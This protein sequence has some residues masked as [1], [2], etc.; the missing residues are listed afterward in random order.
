VASGLADPLLLLAVY[1]AAIMH[2][3]CSSWLHMRLLHALVTELSSCASHGAH[4]NVFILACK[5][6]ALHNWT[7]IAQCRECFV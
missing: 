5:R 7:D 3:G 1:M 6:I 4:E 2:G